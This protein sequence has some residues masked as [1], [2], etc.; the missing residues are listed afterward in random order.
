MRQTVVAVA[1][2]DRQ[3]AN[4]NYFSVVIFFNHM[5]ENF[6]RMYATIFHVDVY[7]RQSYERWECTLDSGTTYN[8]GYSRK[9]AKSQSIRIMKRL[10]DF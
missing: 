1:A 10:I 3:A 8:Q 5:A 6:R 9:V 2:N 7:Y 4:Y